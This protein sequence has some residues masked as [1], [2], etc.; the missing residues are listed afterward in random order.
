MKSVGISGS[1]NFPPGCETPG[2]Y[3]LTPAGSD[4]P[5]ATSPFSQV[6]MSFCEEIFFFRATLLSFQPSPR[7]AEQPLPALDVYVKRAAGYGLQ[8]IAQIVSLEVF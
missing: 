6:L 3:Y 4:P 5:P 2:Y 1:D 8:F 7:P